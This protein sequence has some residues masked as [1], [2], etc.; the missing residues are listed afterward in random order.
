[1]MA[2]Y[3]GRIRDWVNEF[4]RVATK[5]A[6]SCSI[7]PSDIDGSESLRSTILDL[8]EKLS[9]ALKPALVD[10]AYVI[11]NLYEKQDF[12]GVCGNHPELAS[13][14]RLSIGFLGRLRIGLTP[15][16]GLLKG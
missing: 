3:D 7:D 16:C 11:W 6:R 4:Q 1:M 12:D 5:F 8:L 9:T 14:L 15:W 13:S 10:M 2:Y